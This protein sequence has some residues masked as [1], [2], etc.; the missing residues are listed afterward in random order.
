[1]TGPLRDLHLLPKTRDSLSFLYVEHCRVEQEALAIAVV[2]ADGRVPVPV[3]S[4]SVLLLGPGTTVTHAAVRALA[5]SGCLVIWTGEESVRTY[6]VGLGE[7]RSSR[8]LQ[9]QARAWADPDAHMRVVRRLYE[10][11][12][13]ERLDASLTLPQVR[14][15]EG[16]RVRTA[17]A[18]AS[19]TSGVPWSGRAYNRRGWSGA[20]PVNRALSCANSALYGIVHAAIVASGYSPALGFIHTGKML[21]FVYDV[22]DLYKTQVTIPVAFGVGADGAQDIERRTRLLLRDEFAKSRLLARIVPDID[23]ALAAAGVTDEPE[24]DAVDKD[25]ALPGHLWGPNGESVAG[26]R[27]FA[28]ATANEANPCS[29]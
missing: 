4:L 14:G 21:S 11:R 8:N 5:D 15:L 3:A 29:S 26:G 25:A 18:E 22:A 13:S 17:Y 19:R 28:D 10:M 9:R 12:F 6:A 20:D 23:T 1:M 24:L 27:N 2:D 7:T 16:V